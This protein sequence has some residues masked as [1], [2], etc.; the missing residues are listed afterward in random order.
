MK[1]NLS[2]HCKGARRLRGPV[3]RVGRRQARVLRSSAVRSGTSGGVTHTHARRVP[4]IVT[5]ICPSNGSSTRGGLTR[6][7]F[8]ISECVVW[9]LSLGLTAD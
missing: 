8:G 9:C 5:R 6:P 7:I 4:V 2:M 3:R 1:F